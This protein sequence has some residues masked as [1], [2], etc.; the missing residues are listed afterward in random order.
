MNGDTLSEA[1]M[2]NLRR[3]MAEARIFDVTEVY[4]LKCLLIAH[5]V[6]I[7]FKKLWFDYN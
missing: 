4:S 5:D 6:R 1:D 3:R 2:E 7:M